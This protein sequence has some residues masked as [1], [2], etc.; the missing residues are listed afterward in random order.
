MVC[1]DHHRGAVSRRQRNI[2]PREVGKL[3][4][5]KETKGALLHRLSPQSKWS[6]S[7][8]TEPFSPGAVKTLS[9]EEPRWL[10]ELPAEPHVAQVAP[11]RGQGPVQGSLP[12]SPALGRISS[13]KMDPRAILRAAHTALV[14][15]RELRQPSMFY[16]FKWVYKAIKTFRQMLRCGFPPLW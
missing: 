12:A 15:S 5:F 6:T 3:E 11:V 13:W 9:D 8:A 7:I 4:S 16:L 14:R 2:F 10:W 1:V